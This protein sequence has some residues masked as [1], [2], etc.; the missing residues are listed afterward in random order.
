MRSDYYKTLTKRTIT[1]VPDG[2][3]AFTESVVDSNFKGRIYLLD[4]NKVLV[5]QQLN[6][7]ATARLET[8]EVAIPLTTKIVDGTDTYEI[9]FY[10]P[11]S[12]YPLYDLK[13]VK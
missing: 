3:G 12:G 8:D 9:T 11:N 7:E 1:L 13:V 5:N 10:N 2:G 4:G 6:R